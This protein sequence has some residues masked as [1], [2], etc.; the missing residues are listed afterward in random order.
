MHILGQLAA[1]SQV[2]T[3][4]KAHAPQGTHTRIFMEALMVMTKQ[5]EQL[6]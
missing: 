4:M 1:Y 2:Y 3:L 6:K 5:W